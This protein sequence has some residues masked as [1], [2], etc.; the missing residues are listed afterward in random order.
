MS[1]RKKSWFVDKTFIISGGSS[2]IGLEIGRQLL[3]N[4]AKLVIVSNNPEE[5]KHAKKELNNY[6][7]RVEFYKCDITKDEDRLALRQSLE[8]KPNNYV[9]LINCAGITAFG[10]FFKIP[11]NSIKQLIRVNIEGT[12]LFTRQIFSLLLSKPIEPILYLIFISS[13]SSV[14]ELPFF[15]SYAG[16]KAGIDMLFRSI[17]Y[18]LPDNVHVLLMR[19]SVV[20]TKLYARADTAPGANIT[21]RIEK[22]KW[23]LIKPEQVAKPLV[24]AIIKKKSG[25]IYPN[26]M[27]KLQLRMM[28]FPLIKKISQRLAYK[29]LEK[30][31]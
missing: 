26:L 2:G 28:T 1:K 6:V 13:T 27:T 9:G 10:P 16:T 20:N 21:E 4:E 17:R 15:S 23:N 19:P 24:Q 14:L 29:Y 8:S 30:G 5:F 11:I 25:I 22:I 7:D 18:E 31:T 3:M 12:M